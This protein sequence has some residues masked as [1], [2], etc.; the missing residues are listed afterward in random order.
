M[1]KGRKKQNKSVL[2]L[3][4][5]VL[6]S[7][8]IGAYYL[9]NGN[10]VGKQKQIEQVARYKMLNDSL[11][12]ID[13]QIRESKTPELTMLHK[14]RK[15]LLHAKVESLR[16]N[17]VGETLLDND[18][19]IQTKLPSWLINIKNLIYFVVSI[20]I[21]FVSILSFLIFKRK[22]KQKVN[23][24]DLYDQSK[25]KQSK[26]EKAEAQFSKSKPVENPLTK[27]SKILEKERSIE[28]ISKANPGPSDNISMMDALNT[29]KKTRP[30]PE[31]KEKAAFNFDEALENPRSKSEIRKQLHTT[32]TIEKLKPLPTQPDEF[33]KIFEWPL[34]EKPVENKTDIYPSTLRD[35]DT[36]DKRN[37]DIL[38]LARRGFTS[39]E[40][41]RRLKT[42]QDEIEILIKLHREKGI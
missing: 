13:I 9:T 19:P 27:L 36:R 14:E 20:L 6:S 11:S 30:K 3:I 1:P 10:I 39:S 42:S 25:I 26:A 15:K 21:V 41:S 17:F 12:L 23:L 32:E 8:G 29:N 22:R 16:I 34:D 24:E 37:S 33:D 40:I 18:Q 38:K 4:F 31:Q 7:M 5:T 35:L 28:P 2:I